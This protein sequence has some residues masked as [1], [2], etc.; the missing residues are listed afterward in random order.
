V[1][2]IGAPTGTPAAVVERLNRE[3]N[4]ALADPTF[5]A[6]LARTGGTPLPG[7][8]AEFAKLIDGEIDKWAVVVKAA[9]VTPD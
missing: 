4:A 5:A 6:E 8:S 7:T 1:T 9:G 2:G 3:I